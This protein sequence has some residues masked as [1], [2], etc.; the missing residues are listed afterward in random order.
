M[1][2][3]QFPLAK[4]QA[5]SVISAST[6]TTGTN[7]ALTLSTMRWIGALAAWAS[8]TSR[9]MRA[10]VDSAPTARVSTSSRPSALIAPPVTRSPAP[11]ATGR[12]SPVM[13]DSSTWLR[14]SRISPS[15]G[16]R[17]P[18]R[19]TTRSPTAT[20]AIGSSTSLPSRRT[21]ARSGRSALS[22]RIASVVWRLARASS[23]L[24]S[25]MK[26]ISAAAVSKYSSC[27]PAAPKKS[28]YTDRPY[29]ALVPSATSR[30]MLP[31]K[32]FTAFQPAR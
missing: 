20:D 28:S 8:S 29:A 30:S 15:T 19:T 13:S 9:M 32:A 18:G 12:L 6:S 7:T 27:A 14:P 24:P 22:A 10:S 11:L 16:T 3:V 2:E 5:S 25:S 4:P 17:S 21:S 1:A 23:H 26:V 31:V